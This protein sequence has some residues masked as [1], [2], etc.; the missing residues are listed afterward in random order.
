MSFCV[1]PCA[2]LHDLDVFNVLPC[3]LIDTGRIGN[4]R[5]Q[6]RD[7]VKHTNS[8]ALDADFYGVLFADLSQPIYTIEQL[9]F[10]LQVALGDDNLPDTRQSRR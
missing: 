3:R 6:A 4:L 5:F 7:G 10:D 9:H 8:Y 2:H 1:F